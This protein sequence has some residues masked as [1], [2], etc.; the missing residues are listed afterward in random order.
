MNGSFCGGFLEI[1]LVCSVCEEYCFEDIYRWALDG[2]VVMGNLSMQ[3]NS[4][5][6]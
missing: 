5:C 1:F 2:Y 6:I 4:E 3:K